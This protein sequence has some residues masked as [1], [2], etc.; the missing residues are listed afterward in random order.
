MAN[1]KRIQTSELDFDAIKTNLKAY[2]QGQDQFA[3]YDFEGSGMSVLLDVLALN[4]HY[5]ALYTNLA[6]NE[7]FLDSS[8]KR[9]S[10]VS[11]AK[12]LGYVTK[13]ARAATA[14]VTVTFIN[15]T[16]P[17]S[18]IEEIPK[19][20]AFYARYGDKQ[21]SFYTTSSTI[22]SYDGNQCI[23]EGVT[24][25][26]G[27]PLV[28]QYLY[29][30]GTRIVIPN[31][32]VD[33]SSI[34]IV[35]QENAQTSSYTNFNEATSIIGAGPT[36][37]VYFLKE[38]ED[39]LYEVEFGNGVI[40]QALAEGNIITIE[41]NV[42][43]GSTPNGVYT[44]TYGGTLSSGATAY[45]VTTEAAV[46]GAEIESV[47]SIKWNAPRMYASQNRCVTLEDYKTVI[48][49]LYPQAN[50][51]NVWG[52][53]TANPPS[54]GDV[55]ISIQPTANDYLTQ[56][57]KDYLL[58]DILG[59]R[60]MVTVH[61]KIVD[62]IHLHV[63]MDVSFYYNP[64]DTAR[65]AA[66]LSSLVRAAVLNYNTTNLNRFGSILRHSALTRTV[67]AAEPSIQNSII[68][69]K[70]RRD[71]TVTFNQMTQYTVDLGNPIYNS[72]VPEESILSN[73]LNVLN[74]PWVVY[75]DD[76]PT[77]GTDYGVVRMFYYAAG[78]KTVIKNVG[79]VQYSTGLIQLTDLIITG[80]VDS[81]FI[82]TIKPQSNDIASV[83]NQVVSIREDLLTI[84]PNID[85]AADYYKF[86]SSR[87]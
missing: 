77:E 31:P 35:V 19:N 1:N 21:F 28:F 71:V 20:T 5:N 75:L 42:C 84:T 87:N 61:P 79:T 58:N 69:L 37:P 53:E 65:T 63:A 29:T 51:I 27:T 39:E 59:P 12:E 80:L 56:A 60:K 30:A 67:D 8:S 44:F 46:G 78:K 9:A 48:S 16:P 3:D 32:N 6:V 36:T 49:S 68:T 17:E 24:I 52:G 22:G 40:G 26:E 33:T 7:S 72:G 18:G 74:I 73:G 76:L 64:Q 62:P 70:I 86:T 55:F 81:D 41:Y 83:R 34:R 43:S 15:D 82:F 14:Q 11:K 23:L 54:Y 50:S 85:K 57:E 45:V 47:D 4:T 13:S 66:D 2:L 25:K 10:A 38:L